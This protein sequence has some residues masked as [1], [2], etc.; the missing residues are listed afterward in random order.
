MGLSVRTKLL[1]MLAAIGVFFLSV[2]FAVQKFVLLPSYEA[3]ENREMSRT[4]ER[5]QATLDHEFEALN[6]F[7]QD[8]ANWNAMH[9]YVSD[10]NMEDSALF[11]Q[12]N[13][14]SEVLLSARIELL[15]VI[16]TNGATKNSIILD[17]ETSETISLESLSLDQIGIDH[18]FRNTQEARLIATENGP[19]LYVTHPILRSDRSGEVAGFLT[20]GRFF[21]SEQATSIE[22]RLQT[23]LRFLTPNASENL[24]SE[25]VQTHTRNT[26]EAFWTEFDTNN[27]PIISYVVTIPREITTTGKKVARLEW[28]FFLITGTII[29][30]AFGIFI[31]NV[32]IRRT[33][34]L[35]TFVHE[36][37]VKRKFDQRLTIQKS[38]DEFEAVFRQVNELLTELEAHVKEAEQATA[39]AK[40]KAK[41]R[42]EYIARV[43]HELRTPLNGV[44]GMA[45]LLV[46]DDTDVKIRQE[47][48][49]SIVDASES[50]V[51]VIEGLLDISRIDAG[52]LALNEEPIDLREVI[53]RSISA[54]ATLAGTKNIGLFS[55]I[56]KNVPAVVLADPTRLRQIIT[57]LV[58]NAIKFTKKGHVKVDI[59]ANTLEKTENKAEITIRVEDTGSGIE[60]KHLEA[61]FEPFLRIAL[62]VE[63][64]GLGLAIAAR[65]AAHMN[66]KIVATSKI[67]KGSV[68]TATMRFDIS[69]PSYVPP[70]THFKNI[71]LDV[72]NPI[73]KHY[74]SASFTCL[75][76]KILS[77]PLKMD[78]KHTLLVADTAN[79]SNWS[80]QNLTTIALIDYETNSSPNADFILRRPW[81][82]HQLLK[83]IIPTFS[84]AM[85]K[86]SGKYLTLTR[87]LNVLAAEDSR[88]GQQVLRVTLKRL[89]HQVTIVANGRD[90]VNA[91]KNTHFDVVLMDCQ[92]PI[93]DGFQATSEIRSLF[94]D[95]GP[96]IVAL[97][98]AVFPENIQR[99]LDAGMNAVM[100]K[101]FKVEELQRIFAEII[102]A[103]T[104]LH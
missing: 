51:L 34:A 85:R 44:L 60:Q 83:T 93:L 49:A 21:N 67:G 101:P 89:G 102:R 33:Q 26:I 48:L 73:E 20:M 74:L 41:L 61:I 94:K 7:C 5:V 38:G 70:T 64:S 2:E 92:M 25:I 71:I 80:L 37:A 1:S 103:D 98:A 63:G 42:R 9:S 30:F 16:D 95:D 65:L 23:S 54:L 13:F 96:P 14:T 50:L 72:E 81:T 88:V 53:D 28:F 46:D 68:F 78:P 10:E 18:P 62:E 32:F 27:I 87:P 22:E 35:I 29:L 99:C 4:I 8:W 19:L 31:S 17:E 45:R 77:D 76:L 75:G 55:F 12:S 100:P 104:S 36:V 86:M 3:L 11:I 39:D 59:A 69:D 79:L 57:N 90:A 6:L 58:G 66:G 82:L 47:L 56:A 43:S 24:S 52:H 84:E 15:W 91:V 40:F 97:T